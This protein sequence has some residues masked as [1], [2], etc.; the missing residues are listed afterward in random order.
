MNYKTGDFEKFGNNFA[1]QLSVGNFVFRPDEKREIIYANKGVTDL[2][3]CDGYDDFISLVGGCFDGMINPLQ[4]AEV[5]DDVNAQLREQKQETGY[6]F[7]SIYT[8]KGRLLRV[9]NHWSISHDKNEGDIIYGWLFL[10]RLEN[11]GFEFDSVTGL[12]TRISFDKHVNSRLKRLRRGEARKYAVVYINLVNF[13]LLNIESGSGKGDECL[14]E[15]AHILK[16]EYKKA[17][18]SR[19]SDDHFAVFTAYD[20]VLKITEKVKLRFDEKYRE[21]H[22]IIAK[23]G[24]YSFSTDKDFDVE[25]ALSLAKMTCDFI[26]FDAKTDISEYSFNLSKQ[27]MIREYIIHNLDEALEKGWIKVY[28]QPVIR[29]LTGDLCGMESLTRWIDPEVGFLPPD[30]FIGTLEKE[31]CIH[32]LDAYVVEKV[33]QYIH[34]RIEAKLPVVPVSVNFS[35]LDFVL[36][37]M[38]SVVEKYVKEYDVPRD[39]IHIE[40]TESMI[41]SDEDLMV[42]VISRF[43]RAGY[44]I[45]MDDFGS[46]YSSLTMLKDYSFDTLKMDMRFLVPFTDK[47]KSIMRSTVSM[48]KD[49]G[50][51]TLAEGVETKEQL[52]FLRSIGCGMIQGYY[53]GKPEPVLDVFEHLEQ[54]DIVSET[55]SWRRFYETAGFTIRDTDI[56][57]EIIED[58]GENFRTLYMNEAYKKQIF[59][60]D[61][62][63]LDVDQID[64]LI[65]HTAT[66]L[67]AQY[68]RFADIIEKSSEPETFYYT[69]NGNYLRFTGQ[70]LAENNGKYVIKGS[71]LNLSKDQ[72]KK[73]SELLDAKLGEINHLFELVL[74]I[75]P[76]MNL[77]SPL[78]GNLKYNEENEH[79]T[80][81]LSESLQFI[82]DKIV[83]P[84]E[85]NG[86]LEFTDFSNIKD[87][88]EK[89]GKGYV[90]AV[91]RFKQ[92]S[93]L[94]VREEIS[95]MMIPGTRSSEYLYCMKPFIEPPAGS[96]EE[97]DRVRE[98]DDEYSVIWGNIIWKSR[99]MY[100]WK[101][102][103]RRYKGVTMA[104]MD[105]F[106][107][108]DPESLIGRTEE[109]MGWLVDEKS[110]ADQELKMLKNGDRI[111]DAPAQCIAGGMIRDIIFNKIPIYENGR[112]VGVLGRLEDCSTENSRSEKKRMSIRTDP[113]TGLMNAGAFVQAMVDYATQ[114]HTNGKKYG[115]IVFNNRTHERIK[116]SYGEGFSN[117]LL[118]C[119]AQKLLGIVGHKCITARTKDSVFSLLTYAGDGMEL[120]GL[121]EE[122]KIAVESI[123][124]VKSKPVTLRIGIAYNC[125]DEDNVT[126]ENIYEKT[127]AALSGDT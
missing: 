64:R 121:T 70:L 47:A 13:K 62:L 115:L 82:A 77:L 20:N 15:M 84:T 41:A 37:D 124:T 110:A 109:E 7:Y 60:D 98:L 118:K 53:Y 14:K 68:R 74:W 32:K 108:K 80:A 11:I 93:G 88:L 2:F 127:L 102:M 73:E 63:K 8:K 81:V 78:L 5:I 1:K 103:D 48:A 79:G 106:G 33:C 90:S 126:D 42:D 57:L 4:K 35:R 99:A 44:E 111:T 113:V 66:P 46:G 52:D 117:E 114:Y 36:C 65:Y 101:D 38:V 25:E 49:V 50:M 61:M 67:I 87:R 24:I 69:D 120:K 51:K 125:I 23:Y 19:I 34:Q 91:F 119:I 75:R 18:I 95:I 92:K 59:H 56:P 71:I 123:K 105:F 21:K 39:Y 40:I 26:K 86:F 107:V 9:V 16:D 58:D 3:E 43:R 17:I 31:N 100:F 94:F 85:K 30:Q 55:R 45:W 12:D 116:E 96:R 27:V 112:I 83:F 89:S 97:N 22:N 76:E 6:V 122:I 10:H 54:K 104:F 28:F 72:N 29:A